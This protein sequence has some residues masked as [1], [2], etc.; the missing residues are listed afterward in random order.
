MIR[1]INSRAASILRAAILRAGGGMLIAAALAAPSATLAQDAAKAPEPA[2]QTIQTFYLHN[3]TAASHD[4]ND[5]TTALRNMLPKAAIYSIERTAAITVR[6]SD[7]DLTNAQKLIA[8]LDQPKKTWR[9]TYTVTEIDGGKDAAPQHFTLTLA[10]GAKAFLKQG[11]RVPIVTGKYGSEHTTPETQ[12]QYLDVGINLEAS[13]EGTQNSLHLKTKFEQSAVADNSG[14]H[15]DDPIIAQTTME[16][17]S[18]LEGGK[19][20]SLGSVAEPN[21]PHHVQVSV[22]AEAVK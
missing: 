8:S 15:A 20:V 2:M 17:T 22:L 3:A 14:A 12:V 19:P 6:G 21:S 13:L 4:V 18:A 1:K 5:I 16:T 11:S 7:A 9:L 10:E